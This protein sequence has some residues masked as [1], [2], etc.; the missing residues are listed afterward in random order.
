MLCWAVLHTPAV[1]GN[2]QN[3]Q[4]VMCTHVELVTTLQQDLHARRGKGA[5]ERLACRFV[6][7]A[8]AGRVPA[9]HMT[10]QAA[11]G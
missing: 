11:A 4:Q 9:T 8:A 10:G 6:S 1:W 3:Q 7:P 2:Q 5:A